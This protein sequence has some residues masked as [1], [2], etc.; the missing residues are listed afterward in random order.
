M[1]RPLRRTTTSENSST[2]GMGLAY[3]PDPGRPDATRPAV[4]GW[5][6]IGSDAAGAPWHRRI[7]PYFA[8]TSAYSAAVSFAMAAQ[9]K[10]SMAR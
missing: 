5:E 7:A 2:C 1:S 10:S 9:L 8:A 3:W 4:E 6:P